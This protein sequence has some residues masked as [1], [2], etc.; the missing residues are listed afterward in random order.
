MG[1]IASVLSLIHVPEAVSGQSW[2]E[3]SRRSGF[4]FQ[5]FL[6]G[7]FPGFGPPSEYGIARNLASLFRS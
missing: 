4:V 7:L 1:E 5:F 2:A 6:L 3:I